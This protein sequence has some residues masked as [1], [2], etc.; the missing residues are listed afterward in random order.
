MFPVS[1][2]DSVVVRAT[3]QVEDDTKDDQACD[4]DDLDGGEDELS[5]AICTC[6]DCR[7]RGAS[8]CRRKRTCTEHI[9]DN[10]DY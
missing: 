7:L 4:G 9:D 8:E 5:L 3:S 6:M 10:D 2:S 1:E